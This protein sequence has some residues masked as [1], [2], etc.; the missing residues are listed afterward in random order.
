MPSAQATYPYTTL[1]TLLLTTLLL[2]PPPTTAYYQLGTRNKR[3][4]WFG[5]YVSYASGSRISDNKVNKCI[6][7][8]NVK[9]RGYI[10]AVTIYNQPA[11]RTS[12]SVFAFYA[13][14]VCGSTQQKP[15]GRGSGAYKKKGPIA[16]PAYVAVLDKP[17]DDEEEGN[18]D[19]DELDGVWLINLFQALGREPN[20]RT[21]KAL[22]YEDEL[23]PG[24]LLEGTEGD[25][26]QVI[27]KWNKNSIREPN[28]ITGAVV[29]LEEPGG[30]IEQLTTSSNMYMALRDLTE[31]ALRPGSESIPNPLPEYFR[32]VVA[33][34]ITEGLTAPFLEDGIDSPT[35]I[36]RKKI[37]MRR[38]SKKER[39]EDP[40][41]F[42]NLISAIAKDQEGA[43]SDTSAQV[44]L[45]DFL[46]N[47]DD[48]DENDENDE[49]VPVPDQSDLL[50]QEFQEIQESQE[51]QATQENQQN[52]N[53]DFGDLYM[54]VIGTNI[55]TET[56]F[57]E[58]YQAGDETPD[59]ERLVKGKAPIDSPEPDPQEARNAARARAF[60]RFMQDATAIQID[61]DEQ[62]IQDGP[63][64]ARMIWE[65][66]DPIVTYP[67]R[68]DGSR[69][70]LLQ[71]QNNRAGAG[72]A[73]SILISSTDSAVEEA[74]V[75]AGDAMEIEEAAAEEVQAGPVP[76][77]LQQVGVEEELPQIQ[78]IPAAVQG[79]DLQIENPEVNQEE[80]QI[81]RIGAVDAIQEEEGDIPPVINLNIEE[82]QQQP[83]LA[84]QRPDRSEGFL[85]CFLS[86]QARTWE[87]MESS[88]SSRYRDPPGFQPDYFIR[89]SSTSTGRRPRSR[90]S[91]Q[92]APRASFDDIENPLPPQN[93]NDRSALENL[94][95]IE[96]QLPG[97]E[98]SFA[99]YEGFVSGRRRGSGN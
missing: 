20:F 3:N 72:P 70:N 67:V 59:E 97:S 14:T 46:N 17:V 10:T 55:P 79:Q 28:Y 92:S 64:Q 50:P 62:Q 41:G 9:D 54:D 66:G 78:I 68:F 30:I 18:D 34:E 73:N 12:A 43:L 35:E 89:K 27:Y 80:I 85:P 63:P 87:S 52:P 56:A 95:D 53:E 22:D 1:L 25:P 49:G 75:D 29:K 81:E 21:M 58:E 65:E 69:F 83:Q 6:L 91:E 98:G 7:Y 16:K 15:M 47:L 74:Q 94:I 44:E 71:N 45:E 2:L 88:R 26:G 90:Q 99:D 39:A 31:R 51:I 84:Q 61:P 48:D 57:V 4:E 60:E 8:P 24:G 40:Q 93:A 77:P 19:Y 36:R 13:D 32:K 5:N 76:A 11:L 96:D 33:G 23:R 37:E 38:R 82:I 86:P 42:R